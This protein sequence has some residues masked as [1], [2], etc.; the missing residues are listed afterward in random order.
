MTWRVPENWTI[1]GVKSKDMYTM[2]RIHCN[3]KIN[4]K[5]LRIMGQAVIDY[6]AGWFVCTPHN[7]L[8]FWRPMMQDLHLYRIHRSESQCGSGHILNH[9][10]ATLTLVRPPMREYQRPLCVRQRPTY[11]LRRVPQGTQIFIVLLQYFKWFVRSLLSL[12]FPFPIRA[13]S[14][15]RI[16][17]DCLNRSKTITQDWIG[18]VLQGSGEEGTEKYTF[19]NIF[20]IMKWVNHVFFMSFSK[21][22]S[23]VSMQQFNVNSLRDSF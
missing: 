1:S 16:R 11:L 21:G 12:C 18:R 4:A 23:Q 20:M 8:H 19:Y 17:D 2:Y 7:Q 22:H 6:T 15:S 9:M 10:R 14:G 5:T 13:L 3:Y